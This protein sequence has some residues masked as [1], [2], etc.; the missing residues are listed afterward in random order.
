MILTFSEG[1]AWPSTFQWLN[2]TVE[3]EMDE[4]CHAMLVE[5]VAL[6]VSLRFLTYMQMDKF[7]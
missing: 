2:C 1:A 6:L 3:I 5:G 7:D 4:Q